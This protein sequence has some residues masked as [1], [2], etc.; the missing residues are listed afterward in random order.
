MIKKS[1][2]VF[3]VNEKFFLFLFLFLFSFFHRQLFH[4]QWKNFK[5]KK[6]NIY[7]LTKKLLGR[8]VHYTRRVYSK[9]FLVGRGK[10]E[11]KEKEKK[12]NKKKEKAVISL[13]LDITRYS[14][15]E[16]FTFLLQSYVY[17]RSIRRSIQ[18][19][20]LITRYNC[21]IVLFDETFP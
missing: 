12:R 13:H 16:N 9:T 4:V 18:F 17:I 6:A 1:S 5:D 3:F 11:R 14:T 2:N 15:A 8:W 20:N 7:N 21:I 19:I 10:R